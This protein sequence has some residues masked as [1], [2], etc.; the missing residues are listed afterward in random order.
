MADRIPGARYAELAGAG[1][2][3]NV[4]TPAAFDAAVTAFLNQVLP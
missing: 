3:A 4:E 1:H 2:I